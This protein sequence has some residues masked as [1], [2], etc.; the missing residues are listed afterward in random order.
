MEAGQPGKTV[1][2]ILALIPARGGSKSIPNKNIRPFVGHP[3]IAYSIAAGKTAKLVTRV[4]VSTDDETI[5][6][7]AHRYGAEVPFL[8]PSKLAQDDT[9]DF[10]V[11]QHALEW[12]AAHEGYHPEIIV[13][14]RPTSPIRPVDC[15]DRAVQILID[16]PEADSVRGVVLAGQNP[17]KMWQIDSQGKLHPLLPVEGITEPYN[18]P[19]QKLPPTFWQTGHIDVIRVSTIYEKKSLSGEIILPLILDSRYTVDIDTL[20]DWQRAE[21]LVKQSRLEMV[22]PGH[23]SR[24]LPEKVCL[25][26]L[27]FDGVLTDNRVWVNE[28]GHEWVAA[29]R[30]DGLG[31]AQLKQNGVKVLVLS[32]ESNP[33]VAAR[34]QKLGLPYLQGVTDKGA[35]LVDYANKHGI[36]LN[37]AVYLGNDI[38]DIACF[39]HVGC[40]VVVADA[41]PEAR[42]QADL[43]LSQRGGHGAVRELCD[44]ILTPPN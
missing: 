32:T 25:L 8:R 16:H 5:A 20:N 18:A 40:A 35:T 24:P 34:C 33:V 41:H 19:R 21:W 43:V 44:L 39:S 37:Q 11:F 42:Q 10:P 27:D 28:E 15:V 31:L 17:Y 2:E 36:D 26:V 3:I 14:L 1:M 6:K 38:N 13:Q 30:S 29:N 22:I 23:L 7:I 4:I 9:P 12:L